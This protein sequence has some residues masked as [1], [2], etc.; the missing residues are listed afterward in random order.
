MTVA[1]PPVGPAPPKL[2]TRITALLDALDAAVD[3]V[4]EGAA[5]DIDGE[6][7]VATGAMI[8]RARRALTA[9]E[10]AVDA[11]GHRWCVNHGQVPSPRHRVPVAVIGG[12]IYKPCETGGAPTLHVED[13]AQIA[14]AAAGALG[15]WAHERTGMGNATSFVGM[16]VDKLL[17]AFDM[18]PRPGVLALGLRGR[19]QTAG[20]PRWAIDVASYGEPGGP[21]RL[22]YKA[23][24]PA[25]ETETG[26]AA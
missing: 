6:A 11:A 21:G 5:D 23:V 8:T 3:A 17:A 13:R 24:G 2:D 12:T 16:I 10:H 4:D 20:E 22:S 9:I 26:A 18:H 14:R 15:E 1:Q 7:I 19:P 25:P